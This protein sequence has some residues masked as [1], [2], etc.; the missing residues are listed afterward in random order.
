MSF[1]D[2]TTDEELLAKRLAEVEQT[3]KSRPN[4]VNARLEGRYIGCVGSEKSLTV[5]F[6]VLEWETNYYGKLHGGIICT[7]LDHTSGMAAVCF[8][9]G[10]NPTVDIDVHFLRKAELG[11]TLVCKAQLEFAGSKIVHIRAELLSKQS[12][13]TVA[14]SL[15]THFRI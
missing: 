13:K 1:F 10:S 11:D 15:A 7:M 2:F 5:E 6:P 14:T 4:E 12:G 8:L 9:G 3:V